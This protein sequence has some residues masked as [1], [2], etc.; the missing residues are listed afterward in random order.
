MSYVDQLLQR[1]ADRSLHIG[2]LGLGYVGLPLALTS[3]E[4]GL[5][6]TGFD[7]D[8]TKIVKLNKGETTIHHIG[9][10]R[11]AKAAATGRFHCTS[12]FTKSSE[13]DILILCVPTP[14]GPHMEPDMT[15]I[16]DT[17]ASV[18]PYI[19]AGQMVSLEST[20]YPGTTTEYLADPLVAKGFT[21]GEDVF[22]V[23]S[24]EREDPGN[25]NFDT[26]TIAKV[27]GGHT[28][29]CLKVAEA[30]YGIV[31]KKIHPVSSNEVAETSKLLENIFRAVNIGLVNETKIICDRMGI[32]VWEVIRA[33]SSKPFGFMPF[34]P[35][36][37]LGG[38]CIPIDPFYFT[39]K[40]REFGYHTR[41]IE[42]A[43]E[44]NR[45]MPEYVVAKTAE[46]LN[47]A[48]KS[49]KASKVLV[50]GIA[51]KKNIDD[52]RESPA[53]E[54]MEQLQ[55]HG[56]VISYCDPFFP[57]FP[58]MREYHF[59]L[60]SVAFDAATIASFDAVVIATDHDQFDYAMLL[61]KAQL[62]I[63]A[64]GRYP[65]GTAKVVQA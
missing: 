8:E 4:A 50:L 61:D 63:D 41:F 13:P 33:A 23:Y 64:R 19:R 47:N 36:P 57:H 42:L 18:L 27:V 5:T 45:G 59:D 9:A 25:P 26:A 2:I 39:W 52:M 31:I 11:V 30:F 24:P 34:Y 20:T 16:A 15:Y 3:I 56:C 28:P 58:K 51:Y 40:A 48:C 21:I 38:H 32:D 1:A 54:I 43:G 12:D 55:H 44:I 10:E 22:V 7:I 6:V 14:L 29:N 37:G 65:R 62:I 35:G 46:G 60:S 53:V 49:M 17:M